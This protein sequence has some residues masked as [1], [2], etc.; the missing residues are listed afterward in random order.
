MVDDTNEKITIKIDGS[1]TFEDGTEGKVRFQSDDIDPKVKRKLGE[2]VSTETKEAGN[3]PSIGN[4]VTEISLKSPSG[5]PATLENANNPWTGATPGAFRDEFEAPSDQPAISTFDN[6]SDSDLLDIEVTKGKTD[7]TTGED[8]MELLR[9]INDD[10]T[11]DPDAKPSKLGSAIKTRLQ[12]TNRFDP[13]NEF[14]ITGTE[15]VESN[16]GS[17]LLQRVPGVHSPRNWPSVAGDQKDIIYKIKDLRN[18]GIQ[19]MLEASG[20]YYVPDNPD[21]FDSA[22]G[23]KAASTAPGLAR[24]GIRVPTSRFSAAEIAGNINSEFQ[25]NSKFPTLKGHSTLSYGNVNSVLVPFD[26]VSSTSATAAAVLLSITVSEIV[27]A[28]AKVLGPE[29]PIKLPSIEGAIGSLFD[30]GGKPKPD[31]LKVRRKRLGNYLGKEKNKENSRSP[32][33]SLVSGI[34]GGGDAFFFLSDTQN[35]YPK[36]VQRGTEVFF[37][38]PKAPGGFLGSVLGAAAATIGFGP[39]YS[40]AQENPGVF[41]TLMRML[42]R[43][44]QDDIGAVIN[45]GSGLIGSFSGGAGEANKNKRGGLDIDRNVGLDGDPTNLLNAV[46][47]LRDSKL[48][49]FMDILA[50]I[51][52]VTLMIDDADEREDFI[53]S[54]DGVQDSSESG[55]YPNIAALVKKNRLSTKAGSA[56]IGSMAW[57]NDTLRSLYLLPTELGQAE[58]R[59]TGTQN[60]F[61]ILSSN[62]NV[63]SQAGRRIS[64]KDVDAIERELDGCYMPFYFHDLRTNEIIS[65]HAF[66]EN[67]TDSFDAEYAESDGYGRIG[68]VYSYKNTNRSITCSFRV[69]ATNK[70]DFGEMWLKINKLVSLV[71]PQYTAGRLLQGEDQSFYQPF[72]Q[73][74]ANSPMIRLRLGDLFKSNYSEFDLAKLFGIGSRNFTL[75]GLE[76][77][78]PMS[79]DQINEIKDNVV[80]ILENFAFLDFSEGDSFFLDSTPPAGSRNP[81]NVT[82][83]FGDDTE[84]PKLAP[85]V[86]VTVK[87]KHGSSGNQYEVKVD[88]PP[89][90]GK[91]KDLFIDLTDASSSDID[92]DYVYVV[93]KARSA[94]GWGGLPGVAGNLGPGALPSVPG[95][96]STDPLNDQESIKEVSSAQVISDFFSTEKNPIFKAFDSTAGQGLA[97]FI[98]RI[99]F[100]WADARWDTEGLNNRAPMWCKIDIDFAPVHDLNPGIDST[101]AMIAP[102]YN[103]GSLLYLMK[104]QKKTAKQIEEQLAYAKEKAKTAT[105]NKGD[106]ATDNSLT[107]NLRSLGGGF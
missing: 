80:K 94:S 70:K 92:Y 41:N 57:G 32:L 104:G 62:K 76:P 100:D 34:A 25:Q 39:Q 74:I 16:V 44:V 30:S 67:V 85:H 93:N 89:A 2:Y 56:Y 78:E 81:E 105:P 58:K 97:G 6:L 8:G 43:A 59:F 103:I 68:K 1:D 31:P 51:G 47:N 5:N 69:V 13:S 88:P 38:N 17:S 10:A 61:D 106:D 29:S 72:S 27:K 55:R 48:M 63:K 53:S 15:E 60:S 84:A 23:A 79:E 11:K 35:P 45:A 101:G 14:L 18:M 90:N 42:T 36:C 71:Y 66:I 99:S 65:F 102:P 95:G 33:S 46:G 40:L 77:L 83:F 73:L 9:G 91:G 52:D 98:R 37:G 75:E 107:A 21:E 96:I 24:I 64:K 28:L 26:A 86:R 4:G 22:L 49:R 82:I 7:K 19:I 54:I 50:Q 87:R 3:N 20:E 12:S